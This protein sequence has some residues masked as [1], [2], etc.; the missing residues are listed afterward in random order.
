MTRGQLWMI[1][2][3]LAFLAIIGAW[4]AINAARVAAP[5]PVA[6]ASVDLPTERPPLPPA[7]F[8]PA[9][10][11]TADGV[12]R[13]DI[14]AAP[15]VLASGPATPPDAP[16]IVS[17][18]APYSAAP[19]RDIDIP[20]DRP[21]QNDPFGFAVDPTTPG[22]AEFTPFHLI[23]PETLQSDR[24][25]IEIIGDPGLG[26]TYAPRPS[27]NPR[28]NI[29]LAAI[30]EPTAPGPSLSDGAVEGMIL[31]GVF[32]SSG[33]DRALVRTPDG[34]SVSVQPGDEIEGWRVADIAD[35]SIDLTRASQRTTLRLPD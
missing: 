14:F 6:F 21:R 20:M 33:E 16:I 9:Q 4:W 19:R 18:L 28:R 11:E 17:V 1:N 3:L 30:S 35:E 32:R 25:G 5:S 22:Y 31:L 15:A 26:P 13:R 23:P 34:A 29:D 12:G 7:P 10:S 24:A 2:A 8:R 27:I